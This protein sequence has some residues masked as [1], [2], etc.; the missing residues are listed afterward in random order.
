MSSSTPPPIPGQENKEPEK[1][2]EKKNVFTAA[3][4]V[5]IG[6]VLI[7]GL[8]VLFNVSMINS[9]SMYFPKL[10]VAG[11]A[12]LPL[13]LVMLIF[14]GGNVSLADIQGGGGLM[15]IISAAPM[16]H[17]IIWGITFV[18]GIIAA[19]QILAHFGLEI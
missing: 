12:G 7:C 10:L 5:G 13:G 4:A 8:F 16:T 11:I 3:Q 6:L 9:S 2:E 14:K 19:F 15:M 18:V 1:P 17:K